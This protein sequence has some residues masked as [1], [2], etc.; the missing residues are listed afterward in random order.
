M[1]DPNK[2]RDA[3]DLVVERFETAYAEPPGID[4]VLEAARDYLA[5]L[6]S[7]AIVIRRDTEGNWPSELQ[8]IVDDW[9]ID[10]VLEGS[11]SVR[12]LFDALAESFKA[13]A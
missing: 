7:D 2:L 11:V 1:S 4:E 9:A 3:L 13:Q 8:N 6:E 12:N 5:L 10:Y